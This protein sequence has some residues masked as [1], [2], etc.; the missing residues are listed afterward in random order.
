MKIEYE[1]MTLT[2][3]SQME[4]L[5]T[6]LH[7]EPVRLAMVFSKQKITADLIKSMVCV[8]FEL[9]WDKVIQNTRHTSIIFARMSFCYL[10]VE[11]TDLKPNK[12]AAHIKKH[13]STVWTN[14]LSISKLFEVKD[15]YVYPLLKTIINQLNL[16]KK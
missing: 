11:F 8:A 16:I 9:Q 1:R 3:L 6:T 13:R 7:N 2:L 10:C 12:I 15:A 5:L 14:H 4:E